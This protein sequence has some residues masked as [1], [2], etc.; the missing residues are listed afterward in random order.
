MPLFHEYVIVGI[1]YDIHT[2]GGSFRENVQKFKE[3]TFFQRFHAPKFGTSGLSLETLDEKTED[4]LKPR[5]K[6]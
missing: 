1:F 4:W 3:G 6:V 5:Y 2:G